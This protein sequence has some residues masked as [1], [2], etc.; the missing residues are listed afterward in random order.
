MPGDEPRVEAR[1]TWPMKL[2]VMWNSPLSMPIRLLSYESHNTTSCGHTFDEIPRN[3]F[4]VEADV[5]FFDL[6]RDLWFDPVLLDE[7]GTEDAG[8]EAHVHVD[9]VQ[10]ELR[11]KRFRESCDE[12]W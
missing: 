7:A 8:R 3:E 4:W 1:K 2:Y 9:T 6:E 12:T 5:A 10:Q 11:L